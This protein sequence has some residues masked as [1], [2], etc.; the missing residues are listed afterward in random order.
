MSEPNDDVQGLRLLVEEL[1]AEEPPELPWDAIER[2]LMA[3]IARR[4]RVENT[5][6]ARGRAGLSQAF[7]FAAAA[8]C[9][10]LGGFAAGSGE[11]YGPPREA[12]RDVSV[13]SVALAPS[14]PGARGERDLLAL[15]PGDVIQAGDAPVTFSHADTLAWRLAP[16]SSLVVRSLGHD[17]VGHTVALERGS[18]R[19]EVTPR[20]PSEGLIEA[21]AVEV[22]NT[23]VAVHG[24][25]FT[26]TR[27]GDRVIVDVEHGSVAVGPITR[28]S[29]VGQAFMTT[30]HLLIG[31]RRASFSL[32]GGRSAR[33][34]PREEASPAKLS[35]A[36]PVA[37]PTHDDP[38]R[39][40]SPPQEAR[41][42]RAPA[43]IHAPPPQGAPSLPEP[44]AKPS[45]PEPALLTVASVRAQLAQ[46]FA[47]TYEVGSFSVSST[48][49]LVLKPDGSVQSAR[50]DPPV[51]P[52]FQVCASG[53]IAGRF[54]EGP[55]PLDIPFTMNR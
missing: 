24:T 49:R 22:G 38:A 18:I 51:K 2:R 12:T 17:G 25:A 53:A 27:D 39:S 28:G 11:H 23:R 54:A 46:C 30:G 33:F 35:A 40:P 26:V 32:D 41:E 50:F 16:E 19:A 14:E 13:A 20:D 15:M 31:P 4:E 1:R 55:G 52:E 36:T 21:F 47:K 44:T 3:E 7:A 29:P 9:L 10:V 37:A 5:R 42:A 43:P 34:L 48:F 6:A 8:A 45:L